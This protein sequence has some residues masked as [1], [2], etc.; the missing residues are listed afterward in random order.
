MSSTR[1]EIQEM[2]EQVFKQ[3]KDLETKHLKRLLK[4]AQ[5]LFPKN[6]ED[7]DPLEIK[8]KLV[9]SFNE[10]TTNNKVSSATG[11]FFANRSTQ[12]LQWS[13]N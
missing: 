6:I 12:Q 10:K 3:M 13:Q 1:D 9:A 8:R 2:I 5:Y 7:V 11:T 4:N